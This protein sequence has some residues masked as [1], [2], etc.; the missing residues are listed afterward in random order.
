MLP[1]RRPVTEAGI[2]E[3]YING[4]VRISLS[5]AAPPEAHLLSD[6]TAALKAEQSERAARITDLE[7]TL[8]TL[9]REARDAERVLLVT[10][11]D[12]MS[13]V[14]EREAA[15]PFTAPRADVTPAAG[16]TE[17]SGALLT[18]AGGAELRAAE[19]DKRIE[20]AA[21]YFGVAGGE[22]VVEDVGG[23]EAEAGA[24][25]PRGWAQI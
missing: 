2:E 19:E 14:E 7:E 17:A 15:I 20:G 23:R 21:A 24:N 11:A 9:R 8:R 10:I 5:S 6:T 3:S 13:A 16:S 12:E 18:E 1:L 22:D 4:V 25:E